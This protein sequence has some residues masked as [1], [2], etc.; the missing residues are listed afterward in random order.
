MTV[1]TANELTCIAPPQNEG[2]LAGGSSVGIQ[3][4]VFVNGT[5]STQII[6]L[7]YSE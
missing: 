2:T 5:N 7:T 3:V 4:S 1:R 6:P